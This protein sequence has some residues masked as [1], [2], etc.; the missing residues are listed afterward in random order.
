MQDTGRIHRVVFIYQ[1]EN[2]SKAIDQFSR[3]LGIDSFEGPHQIEAFG[4]IVS[5][6]WNAGIE[7]VAPSG[8][9]VYSDALQAYLEAHGEGFFTMVYQVTDLSAAEHRAHEQGFSRVGDYIDALKMHAEW[10]TRFTVLKEAILVPIAG[11]PVTLIQSEQ[12]NL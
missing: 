3:A 12:H 1:Q 7:L 6:S 11:V 4:L 9:G 10:R 8:K 2:L 5:V